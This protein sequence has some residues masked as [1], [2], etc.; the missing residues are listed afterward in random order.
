MSEG[1][2]LDRICGA[3]GL[4]LVLGARWVEAVRRCAA[5]ASLAADDAALLVAE[6]IL[7]AVGPEGLAAFCGGVGEA[8][9]GGMFDGPGVNGPRRRRRSP[10]KPDA[11]MGGGLASAPPTRGRPK[12]RG[13][14]AAPYRWTLPRRR[15][16]RRLYVDL[17]L[18]PGAIA[19]RMGAPLTREIVQHKVVAMGLSAERGDADRAARRMDA[20]ELAGEALRRSH[21]ARGHAVWSDD[22]VATLR[23]L[24]LDEDVPP[25][26]IARSLGLAVLAVR[27]RIKTSG[28]AK[29]R[30]A[31]GKPRTRARRLADIPGLVVTRVPAGVARGVSGLE[32][33]V[34]W[35]APPQS[36]HPKRLAASRQGQIVAARKRG[37]NLTAEQQ[38][39]RLAGPQR[40]AVLR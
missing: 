3:S 33:A 21:E 6:A 32:T 8:M 37:L 12:G 25:A 35:V 11:A 36:I 34:G 26:L 20:L 1:V 30:R 17:G 14:S 2:V 28:L 16:L 15:E 4:P 38:E 10:R 18:G 23:R 39:R 29:E 13:N 7:K 27:R 24:Y 19:R 31:T 5:E 40:Q 22:R 9:A